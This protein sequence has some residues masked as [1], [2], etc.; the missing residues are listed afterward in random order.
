M[1]DYRLIRRLDELETL[2]HAWRAVW[3]SDPH[4][5]PFQ[6]PAWLI[7]WARQFARDDLRAIAIRERGLLIG[8]LPFYICRDPNAGSSQLLLLGAGTSDYLDGVFSPSCSPQHIRDAVAVL[9]CAPGWQTGYATQLR[10]GSRLLQAMRNANHTPIAPFQTEP[11]VRGRAVAISGL[12]RK[13]RRNVLYHRNRAR[14]CGSLDLLLADDSNCLAFFELLR[15]LHTED[16]AR[17]GQHG[18]LAD[19]RVLAWHREALP[20][21]ARTGLLRLYALHLANELIAAYYC[22]VDP[23]DR[24][25]RSQYFYLPAYAPLYGN[26]SPGT[27][28]TAFAMEYA[29]GEGI[30]TADLLRGDE[31][32]KYSFGLQ[33]V[34]T[35]GFK[36]QPAH[37][38]TR[39]AQAA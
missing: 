8:V 38:A 6:H 13:L 23:P 15:R 27:L 10:S 39:F 25:A 14:R 7:P 1:P 37:E 17:R 20:Q 33:P 21:L 4:S 28:L 30:V 11:C 9:S 5:T 31:D 2:A 22:L 29:A 16:W 12:P 36:L 34:P 19:P 32:Y 18:V 24:A 3:H 26:F 35:F